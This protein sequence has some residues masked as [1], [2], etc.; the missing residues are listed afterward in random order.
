M[1]RAVDDAERAAS[2]LRDAVE[3][4]GGNH[5]GIDMSDEHR[6]GSK[7]ATRVF[8]PLL[9]VLLTLGI[10]RSWLATRF[11]GFTMDEGW[12]LVAG[13]S[14]VRTGDYRLNPEQPPL[15]KLWIGAWMPERS[16]EL[17][18]LRAML[19]KSGE[20]AYVNEALYLLNDP[21]R[22]QH[23]ARVSMMTLHALLIAALAWCL[24]RVTGPGVALVATALLLVDPSVAAH[25][26]LVMMD[27]SMALLAACAVLLC[28]TAFD[29]VRVRD[30]ALAALALG[31]TLLTKHSALDTIFAVLAVAALRLWHA[32]HSLRGEAWLG[33]FAGLG[34]ILVGAY[35]VLW[36]GFGFRYHEHTAATAGIGSVVSVC[37]PAANAMGAHERQ[38]S[39]APAPDADTSIVHF[40]R[41]LE[42]KV[43]DLRADRFRPFLELA[44]AWHMLPRAYLWGLA[45][46]L[47][48]GFDGRYETLYVFGQY[49]EGNRTPWYFFPAILLVKLPLGLLALAGIGAWLLARRCLSASWQA[50]IV[51]L[52][53]LAIVHLV[54]LMRGHSGYAGV[55][56][57]LPVV[58]ALV[59][60]GA[61][62][63]VHSSRRW[64]QGDGARHTN[65]RGRFSPLAALSAAALI[66]A[67]VSALPLVRPW[68]YYNA[69]GG[70]M[71]D[72]WRY[73]TDDGVDMRQRTRD[74]AR[75]YDEHLRGSER[76]V[77]E[78][79]DIT[80]EE[81]RT[82]GLPLRS[83]VDTP[84][85]SSVVSGTIFVN[86]RW[87]QPRP[88]YDLSSLRA[89]TPVARTGNLMVYEGSF[90][91]PWLPADRRRSQAWQALRAARPDRARAE[92]LFAEVIALYPEDYG[93]ALELGNLR[94]ERGDRPG[95]L[96]AYS[97]SHEHLSPRDGL[98]DALERQLQALRKGDASALRPIR[99]PWLE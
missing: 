68:E 27:L 33:R 45:D 35:V 34:V 78:L 46:T 15:V 82:R 3:I 99:N 92:Q 10:T 50:A 87:L 6:T 26:P 37:A 60:L 4:T 14:H 13:A 93:S 59:L 66:A 79:Y 36:A 52:G 81:S 80:G 73:F 69:L 43:A 63:C 5:G 91:F 1:A 88:L 72:G 58:P 8:W 96:A 20:R 65:W 95:A 38:R 85:A 76:V 70:G 24:R 42:E 48:T 62:A 16:F 44:I 39:C 9:L 89:A 22:V 21:D 54:F 61:C 94:L 84:E 18:P 86:A 55:R 64:L 2:W 40:N 23:R 97:V 71:R 32:R 83:I 41:A 51:A 75:Y 19:D 47:R 12:H 98:R 7:L 67:L 11:D 29:S 28:Y 49:I 25:L 17:P 74:L 90:D 77:Y 57:A 31:L 30:F 56:H 53:L